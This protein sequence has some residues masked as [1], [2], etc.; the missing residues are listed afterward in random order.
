MLAPSGLRGEHDL[1]SEENF[2][3]T[4]TGALGLGHLIKIHSWA[5]FEKA[6]LVK[7]VPW[8]CKLDGAAVPRRGPIGHL[9]LCLKKLQNCGS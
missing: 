1:N 4:L 9:G 8:I 5:E 2:H 7:C 6:P 3:S